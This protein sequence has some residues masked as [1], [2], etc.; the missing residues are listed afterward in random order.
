MPAN[1]KVPRGRPFVKGQSGNPSGRPKIAA[2]VRILAKQHTRFAIDRLVHLAEKGEPDGVQLNAANA[3]LDRGWGRTPQPLVG[4]LEE[5]IAVDVGVLR[6]QAI[7]ALEAAFAEAREPD[8]NRAEVPSQPV[9]VPTNPTRA[10]ASVE[11]TDGALATTEGP[12]RAGLR[13]R[14]NRGY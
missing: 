3:L 11:K 8:A 5:P 10:A 7:E 12:R 1:R 6:R 13:R 9:V 2:D 4:D 14:L